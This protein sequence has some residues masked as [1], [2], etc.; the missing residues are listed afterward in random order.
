MKR[1]FCKY[2]I[3]TDAVVIVRK[4]DCIEPKRRNSAL[5]TGNLYVMTIKP[6]LHF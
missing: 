5:V 1:D 4:D 6:T 3:P 2:S